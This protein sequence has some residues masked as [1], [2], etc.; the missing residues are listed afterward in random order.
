MMMMMGGVS[1]HQI[2]INYMVV[3]SYTLLKKGGDLSSCTDKIFLE[4]ISPRPL[5]D[6]WCS[7]LDST[8]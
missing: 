4:T 2:K 8:T 5:I 3:S 6:F 1:V 7:R